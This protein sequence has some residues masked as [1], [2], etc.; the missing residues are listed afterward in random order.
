MAASSRPMRVSLSRPLAIIQMA[1]P[2]APT[3]ATASLH[4]ATPRQAVVAEAQVER[5]QTKSD[6]PVT[7]FDELALRGLVHPNIVDVITRQM[8]LETMTD[9]QSRTIN[10]ALSGSDVYVLACHFLGFVH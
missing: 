4:Y 3:L 6:V 10:E 7:R 8:K 1:A 9:V 5:P 2:R